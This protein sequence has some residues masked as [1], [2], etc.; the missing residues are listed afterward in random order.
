MQTFWILRQLQNKNEGLPALL[1]QIEHIQIRNVA[2][3]RS[4]AGTSRRVDSFLS[5]LA[6]VFGCVM[7]ASPFA[8]SCG[9]SSGQ[10]SAALTQR[11]P[12]ALVRTAVQPL[13]YIEGGGP[14]LEQSDFFQQVP[15]GTLTALSD[16]G[17]V[18]LKSCTFHP[19]TAAQPFRTLA[20]IFIRCRCVKRPLFPTTVFVTGIYMPAPW[21]HLIKRISVMWNNPRLLFNITESNLATWTGNV[22]ITGGVV[23]GAVQ[24]FV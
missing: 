16:P 15:L 12:P 20:W 24:W 17:L 23:F 8:K 2:K 7:F 1:E 4:G 9:W 21:L 3:R 13:N 19:S 14:E 18:K 6:A 22:T 11:C 10:K 5:W